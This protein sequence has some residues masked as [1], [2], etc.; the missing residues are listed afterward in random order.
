MKKPEL[1]Q[2]IKEEIRNVLKDKNITTNQK[3][4]SVEEFNEGLDKIKNLL[5][6]YINQYHKS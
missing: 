3:Y 2:I 1:K 6:S 4:N 5:D